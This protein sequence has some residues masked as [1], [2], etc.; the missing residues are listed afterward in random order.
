MTGPQSM[1]LSPL[2]LL[3]C[4]SG[5]DLSLFPSVQ[6]SS[7]GAVPAGTALEKE[8]RSEHH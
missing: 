8:R 5:K 1:C 2:T 7:G 6:P 4:P 3:A